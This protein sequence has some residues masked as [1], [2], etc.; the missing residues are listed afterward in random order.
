MIVSSSSRNVSPGVYE[1]TARGT[2]S[3]VD[4]VL[5]L[6][7]RLRISDELLLKPH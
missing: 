6:V 4:H 3:S 2:F 7:E 1:V 5:C